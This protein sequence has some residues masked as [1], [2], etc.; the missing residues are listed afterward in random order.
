M[1]G[2][3]LLPSGMA[4]SL[5]GGCAAPDAMESGQNLCTGLFWAVF[6]LALGVSEQLESSMGWRIRLLALMNLWGRWGTLG[7]RG[8]TGPEML[9]GLRERPLQ[10]PSRTAAAD[11]CCRDP[12]APC[13]RAGQPEAAR[14]HQAKTEK[15]PVCGSRRAAMRRDCQ[16]WSWGSSRWT[17]GTA[18][19]PRPCTQTA[20]PG[21]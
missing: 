2:L 21:P 8:A 16:L 7:Q 18:S 12:D 3:A 19:C 10:V 6:F 5:G 9:G 17:A 20:E 15:L 14:L 4:S 13:C 11:T 1:C